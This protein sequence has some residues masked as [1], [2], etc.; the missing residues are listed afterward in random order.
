MKNIVIKYTGL[1]LIAL[2]TLA[3]LAGCS[4]DPI[5]ADVGNE[6]ITKAEFDKSFNSFKTQYEKQY[7]A[8]IWEQEEDGR[9]KI[10]IVR[11]QILD[12]LIDTRLVAQKAKELNV[13]VTEDAVNKEL[14]NSKGY[15]ETEAKFKE[16][17]AEQ[18][19][20]MDYLAE[21]IRKDLLF[22]NL[23]EKINEGTAVTDAEVEAY[24]NGHKDEF[25]EAKASHI[26]VATEAEA[27]A[28]KARLDKGEDFAA[29]AK[30]LSLD[31]SNKESGGDLGSFSRGAMVEAFDKAVFAM[32]AG[33]TSEPVKTNYGYHIIRSQGTALNTLE[34]AAPSIKNNLLAAKKETV[35]EEMI[36]QMKT[37][38]PVKKYIEK[39]K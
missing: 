14:E 39:L 38:V 5:V 9:K 17:L 31:T 29:L 8:A 37:A 33:E 7:G 10:D 13:S 30:E 3:L 28:V 22:T 21:M 25:V 15:F 27:Q 18:K 2:C 23:Y 1:F 6:K 19:I 26:L 4:A 16:F 36:K 12:M 35:Y 34:K 24:Y 11:E 32:K 20:T